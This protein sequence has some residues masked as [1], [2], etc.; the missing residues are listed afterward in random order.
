MS[1][2]SLGGSRHLVA[3]A[4][5]CAWTSDAELTATLDHRATCAPGDAVRDDAA[6]PAGATDANADLGEQLDL[7]TSNSWT[8]TLEEAGGPRGVFL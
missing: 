7:R 6:F 2:A 4:A 3:S 1:G 8:H 5:S